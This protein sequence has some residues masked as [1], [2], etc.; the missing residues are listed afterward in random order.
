MSERMPAWFL[1]HGHDCVPTIEH[2]LPLLV[3]LGTCTG[4]QITPLYRDWEYGSLAL[5]S[6]SCK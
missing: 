3:T 5:H 1:A 2:Y 6:Y 4:E